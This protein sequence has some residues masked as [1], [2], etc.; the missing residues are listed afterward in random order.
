MAPEP[1]GRRSGVGSQLAARPR[2][3]TCSCTFNHSLHLSAQDEICLNLFTLKKIGD[4]ITI[5]CGISAKYAAQW[6]PVEAF[7]ELIQNWRDGIIKSFH[8]SESKVQVT[9][10]EDEKQIIYRLMEREGKCCLGYI[11][12]SRIMGAGTVDILNRGATLQPWNLDMGGTT[13][14]NEANQ[15]G[16]HG[17]GI[18]IAILVLM[19]QPQDHAVQC[20]SGGYW[21][22][23][24]FDSHGKLVAYISR[25]PLPRGMFGPIRD[26]WHRADEE[27][28]RHPF[29]S[30]Y[31]S[32]KTN[33]V[34]L[35]I[36]N[37]GRHEKGFKPQKEVTREE[38]KEWTKAALFLQEVDAENIVTTRDGD[39]IFDPR[40]T[41]HVY[42]TG[43]LLEE[44]APGRSASITGET[45]HYGHNFAK[46]SLLNS[47]VPEYADAANAESFITTGG[48]LE[49][50]LKTHLLIQFEGKWIYTSTEKCD[51][52]RFDSIIE[53]FGKEPVEVRS[54]YWRILKN[55]GFKTAA[56]M[57]EY[58][59]WH[60][61]AASIPDDTFAQ[62]LH[63][64][65]RA[66]MRSN[67]S[68][69]DIT[70]EFV[71]AGSLGLDMFFS[72]S[73]ELLK[74]HEKRLT[75]DGAM[76]EMGLSRNV[77]MYLS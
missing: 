52:L 76:T 71:Q 69:F 37:K 64:I 2:N 40:F 3:G 39:L 50:A 38:F 48:T 27:T 18:K 73:K 26:V 74:I 42:M 30:L 44:S 56:E 8:I 57:E 45:L 55:N 19:R 75:V 10:Q 58:K 1:G 14:E 62:N 33:T 35:L 5:H 34:R 66:G 4:A 12:W 11:R 23:F 59:F 41:G 7:R 32:G 72:E 25:A 68:T 53:G 54:Y 67:D 31:V 9:C 28:H 77:L 36:D 63:H 22:S 60:V 24:Y 43:L 70:V 15:A 16:A 65:I 21:W 61:E 49:L 20:Y 17:E 29:L 47:R 13:K 6:T 51:N 46:G